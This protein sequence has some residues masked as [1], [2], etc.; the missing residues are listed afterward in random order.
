[1][2]SNGVWLNVGIVWGNDPATLPADTPTGDT[3]TSTQWDGW[4]IT[5]ANK[6]LDSSVSNRLRLTTYMPREQLTPREAKVVANFQ[7]NVTYEVVLTWSGR[8]VTIRC[9]PWAEQAKLGQR[10]AC[11]CLPG[12]PPDVVRQLWRTVAD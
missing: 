7:A 4:R 3:D 10:S 1:M 6:A 11:G 8:I 2:T 12:G 9:R 5:H